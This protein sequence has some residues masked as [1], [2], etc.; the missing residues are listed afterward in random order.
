MTIPEAHMA[1]A[2]VDS[3]RN[4]APVARQRRAALY[5]ACALLIAIPCAWQPHIQ[6]GDL[7]SHLYN[8][9]LANQVESGPLPGLSIVPQFTN[10][11]FDH[12]LSLLLKTGSVVLAE[13][14]AVV[15]AVQI[16]FWGC[17]AFVFAASDRPAW[18]VA[19][20]LA[21][22]AYG[23]V[24]RLGFFNFYISVGLCLLAVALLWR[25]RGWIRLAAFPLALAAFAAHYLPMLWAAA[26]LGYALIARRLK[27]GQRRWLVG[28]FL[29]AIAALAGGLAF[30]VPSR[31]TSGIRIDSMFG[32]D[33]LLTW[34][35]QY[36]FITAGLLCWWIWLLIRRFE[37]DPALIDQP[38]VQL[39]IL[40]AAACLLMPDSIWLPLYTGGLAFITIRLSLLSA[41][42]FCA[43]IARAPA[44]MHETLVATAFLAAFLAFTFS[45]E[46]SL[47]AIEQ[48][49]ARAAAS[50]PPGARAISTL[51]DSWL[52][53]QSLTHVLDRP[54]IGRCYDFGNYE[55][56]TG[57][58]RLRAQPGNPY[59]ISSNDQIGDL[60]RNQFVF[61]RSDFDLYRLSPCNAGR[62]VCV[63]Q[64]HP[65][66]RLARQE[67][68]R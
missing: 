12:L 9:W 50:L 41:I 18:A 52:L 46:R 47:N 2:P 58:F 67:I 56:S 57:H 17:F 32:T 21:M 10:V 24:F 4:S 65:G 42:L 8:A 35:V 39:W 26:L 5:L 20:F 14:I 59:V 16:F 49:T 22:L 62:D 54:C 30:A 43:V 55:P 68:S 19:P 7:S 1:A 60:E 64:V 3:P 37:T 51:E 33:Q 13:R 45:D 38:F 11:L 61:Q 15:A 29:A 53:I 66:E 25:S 31:W 28:S 48:K 63:S 40:G 36:K 6:A 34:G 44:R 23:A 27:P